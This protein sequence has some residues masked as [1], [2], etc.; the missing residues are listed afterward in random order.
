MIQ[1]HFIAAGLLI[2]ITSYAL[3]LMFLV[4]FDSHWDSIYPAFIQNA[5]MP[6]LFV[7]I[8][9]YHKSSRGQTN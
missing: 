5:A 4:K 6:I 7:T 8:L 1:K 9:Y 3:Q 2:F